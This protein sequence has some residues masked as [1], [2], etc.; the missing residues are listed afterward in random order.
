MKTNII[1]N[2]IAIIIVVATAVQG[3][4]T[5]G[6]EFNWWNLMIAAAVALVAFFTGKPKK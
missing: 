4:L 6:A 1:T 2:V 5:S 3:Y